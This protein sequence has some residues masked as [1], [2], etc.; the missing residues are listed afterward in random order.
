MKHD[1][2]AQ[3][4]PMEAGIL[5]A[6]GTYVYTVGIGD[7]GVSRRG[8]CERNQLLVGSSASFLAMGREDLV[9]QGE[10]KT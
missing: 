8:S 2:R 9:T 1:A 4:N 10:P 6:Y 3:Q 5:G 7:V